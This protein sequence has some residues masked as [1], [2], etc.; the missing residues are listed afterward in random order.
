MINLCA[1]YRPFPEPEFAGKLPA[2]VKPGDLMP[3]P[4]EVAILISR[5]LHE[6]ARNQ[7]GIGNSAQS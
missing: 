6:I 1:E 7:P 4:A 2:K 5:G 3:R